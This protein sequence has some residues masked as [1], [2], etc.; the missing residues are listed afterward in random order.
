MGSWDGWGDY[1]N[2]GYLDLV[3]TRGD[4]AIRLWRNQ[5]DGSF[6]QVLSA[7]LASES[8][9]FIQSGSWVDFNQDGNLDLFLV[10]NVGKDKLFLGNGQ[11]NHWLEVKLKGTLSNRLAVGARIFVTATIRGRGLRQMRVITASDCDQSLV[12]HFGLGDAGRVQKLRVEWP[13]GTVE[14]LVNLGVDQVVRLVEPSLRGAFGTDG[15]FR[16]TMT[17][18]TNQAYDLEVSSDLQTWTALTNCAGPGPN[19]VLE[20]CDP[21]T[22]G[23]QRYYRLSPP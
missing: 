21:T 2:D 3:V 10:T 7:S 11:G 23:T 9:T 19:G 17:G 12:A 1:D 4:A 18:N 20:V 14:E 8:R 22:S 16:I 6:A 13:S 5:G 15:L